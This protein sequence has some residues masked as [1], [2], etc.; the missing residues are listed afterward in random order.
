[1]VEINLYFS[2]VKSVQMCL[3]TNIRNI[4]NSETKLLNIEKICEKI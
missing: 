4:L 3:M 2:E 1:M